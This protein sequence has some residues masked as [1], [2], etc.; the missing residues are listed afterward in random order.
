MSNE[1][2]V[3]S[4]LR[5]LGRSDA[6]ALR[7]RASTLD[8][9]ALIAEEARVPAWSPERDYSSWPAGGPVCYEEQVYKLL[10]PHNAAYY[11]GSTPA[12]TPALWSITHTKDPARAKPWMA[13]LGTSGM[14]M[15]NEC[16]L[17]SGNTYRCKRD[18]VVHDPGALPEAW[19]QLEA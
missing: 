13:P 4:A 5:S 2:V 18:N 16:C 9:T 12:N 7:S 15:T 11:P 10:Q 14:Y 19:E 6:L 1:E 3:L 8:G 17:W